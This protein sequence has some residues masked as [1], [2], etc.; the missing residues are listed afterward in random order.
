MLSLIPPFC[1]IRPMPLISFVAS[2]SRI[3]AKYWSYRTQV[4]DL[5]QYIL[6]VGDSSFH[7]V[8]FRMTLLREDC[9]S[10]QEILRGYIPQNE[11]N[12][13]SNEGER[14]HAKC[15]AWYEILHFVHA[16]FGMAKVMSSR[17]YVRNPFRL[18][19]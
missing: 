12:V 19:M 1:F 10:Y 13:I 14:S 15:T 2:D 8:P 18:R 5:L 6:F 11:I 9:I 16:M 17:T 4:R 3:R 7:F